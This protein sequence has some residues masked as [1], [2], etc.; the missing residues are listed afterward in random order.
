M[1]AFSLFSSAPWTIEQ[2]DW[3]LRNHFNAEDDDY[4]PQGDPMAPAAGWMIPVAPG[5]RVTVEDGTADIAGFPDVIMRRQAALLQG[6]PIR[7]L[8]ISFKDGAVRDEGWAYDPVHGNRDTGYQVQN[9][10]LEL[11]TALQIGAVF[12]RLWPVAFDDLA[13]GCWRPDPNA[14]PSTP[15]AASAASAAQA[16]PATVMS[17]DH[18][19]GYESRPAQYVQSPTSRSTRSSGVFSWMWRH[20]LL[21][22]LLFI[23]VSCLVVTVLPSPDLIMVVA[24]IAAIPIGLW[25]LKWFF[26]HL[27]LG[28]GNSSR[29]RYK[30][31]EW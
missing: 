3:V 7:R 13:G 30:H 25:M 1:R 4:W 15:H 24:V 17:D 18:T 23:A 16:R 22:W 21:S 14:G 26:W 2:V 5:R 6:Q 31:D 20:K 27:L 10:D 8:S 11:H 28:G 12:A 29:D 9:P 19:V